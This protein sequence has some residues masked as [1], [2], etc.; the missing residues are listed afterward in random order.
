[1]AL[2]RPSSTTDS[3]LFHDLFNKDTRAAALIEL[4]DDELLLAAVITNS[5]SIHPGA[6]EQRVAV[7]LCEYAINATPESRYR[8]LQEALRWV[9]PSVLLP[10]LA[11]L[12]GFSSSSASDQLSHLLDSSWAQIITTLVP[13]R[14][15]ASPLPLSADVASLL[16]LLP[17]CTDAE[18]I[19][20]AALMRHEAV[21]NRARQ[22]LVE[23]QSSSVV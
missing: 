19:H 5:G 6:D 14:I 17:H 20:K 15:V 22:R 3:S 11:K 23:L 16:R 1:M 4:S 9:R 10:E 2:K 8:I 7:E 18:V 13:A 12:D 21:S